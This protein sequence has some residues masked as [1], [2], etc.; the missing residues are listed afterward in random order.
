VGQDVRDPGDDLD[1][2]A[3]EIGVQ[4]RRAAGQQ[5]VEAFPHQRLRRD[6]APRY[7]DHLE[8]KILLAKDS[9]VLREIE[10]RRAE[11]AIEA[12]AQRRRLRERRR[13]PKTSQE[14][15]SDA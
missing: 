9:G 1:L 6:R 8:I 13:R 4:K 3:A 14:E 7:E 2:R 15:K 11:K 12:D 5:D 10:R